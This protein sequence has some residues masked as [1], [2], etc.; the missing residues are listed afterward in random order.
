VTRRFDV[1]RDDPDEPYESSRLRSQGVSAGSTWISIL[2][3]I[4]LLVLVFVAIA[5]L[6]ARYL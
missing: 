4:V 6:V 3:V 1:V 5:V 2:I